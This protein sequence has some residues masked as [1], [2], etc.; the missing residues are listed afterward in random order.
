VKEAQ[1]ALSKHELCAIRVEYSPLSKL[2]T[3]DGR[4]CAYLVRAIDREY[5]HG[6][7]ERGVSGLLA[8]ED[9]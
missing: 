8:S 2:K 7:A 3:A 9:P 1:G 5:I 6:A 4:R